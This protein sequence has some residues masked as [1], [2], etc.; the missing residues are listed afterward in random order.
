MSVQRYDLNACIGCKMCNQICPM[1]VFRFDES[2][3]KSVIAYPENC[4]SCGQCYL[5]CPG[6]SLAIGNAMY[7]YAITA[8]RATSTAYDAPHKG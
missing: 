2:A 7:G 6:R 5:Y 4:Q 8:H 3:S 1:D